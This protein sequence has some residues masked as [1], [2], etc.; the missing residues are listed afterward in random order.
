MTSS[1]VGMS[2]LSVLT[3]GLLGTIFFVGLWWTVGRVLT[4]RQPALLI[5]GSMLGRTALVVFGFYLVSGGQWQRLLFCLLGFVV[6]RLIVTRMLPK[7]ERAAPGSLA[8]V[9][10]HA[11]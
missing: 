2:V 1:E 4:A 3:G 5:L 7:G 6:A 10:P 8:E 11:P 9:T